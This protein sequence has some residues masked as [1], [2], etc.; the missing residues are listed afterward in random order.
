[1]GWTQAVFFHV[2]IL[3]EIQ[4]HGTKKQNNIIFLIVLL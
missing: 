3:S 4:K 2:D 1:M